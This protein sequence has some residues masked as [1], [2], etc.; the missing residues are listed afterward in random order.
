MFLK[1]LR[2]PKSRFDSISGKNIMEDMIFE[3]KEYVAYSEL[4]FFYSFIARKDELGFLA[5][6]C[7]PLLETLSCEYPRPQRSVSYRSTSQALRRECSSGL[8][9]PS[10]LRHNPRIASVSL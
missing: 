7:M 3:T 2:V 1:V 9:N 4:S 6:S 8:G 5:A 10:Y